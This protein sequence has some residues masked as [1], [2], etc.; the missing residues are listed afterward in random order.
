MSDIIQHAILLVSQ[1][2]LFGDFFWTNAKIMHSRGAFEALI[3]DIQGSCC[4]VG[5]GNDVEAIPDWQVFLVFP[6]LH[7]IVAFL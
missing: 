7:V 1:I 6:W 4:H 2:D 5:V 3:V